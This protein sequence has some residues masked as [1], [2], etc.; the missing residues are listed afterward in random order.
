MNYSLQTDLMK[1]VANQYIAYGKSGRELRSLRGVIDLE[2][3][4]YN[5]IDFNICRT[6]NLANELT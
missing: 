5:I 2:T 1:N 3:P 6:L 4:P